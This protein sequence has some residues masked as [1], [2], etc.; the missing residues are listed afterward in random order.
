MLLRKNNGGEKSMEWIRVIDKRRKTMFKYKFEP[1]LLS[2]KICQ[3]TCLNK[4]QEL[5]KPL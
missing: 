5:L 4:S 2:F 3:V 1:E